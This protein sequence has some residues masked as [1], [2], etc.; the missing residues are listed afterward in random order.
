MSAK[1][2]E[3]S[4]TGTSESPTKLAVSARHFSFVIDEPASF[5]VPTLDPTRSSTPWGPLPDA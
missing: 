3:C 4:V 5:G 1:L 2:L